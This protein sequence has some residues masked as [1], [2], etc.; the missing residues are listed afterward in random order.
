[1][2][3]QC[4]SFLDPV[5]KLKFNFNNVLLA[6]CSCYELYCVYSTYKRNTSDIFL[7]LLL[8]IHIQNKTW[9]SGFYY[10]SFI[11]PFQNNSFIFKR[12]KSYFKAEWD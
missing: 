4:R 9:H 2:T 6:T 10:S 1:M 12:R 5:S 7:Y 11:V 8:F 3:L